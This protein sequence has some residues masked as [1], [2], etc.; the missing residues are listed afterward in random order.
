[1]MTAGILAILPIVLLSVVPAA[2]APL[3]GRH[4]LFFNEDGAKGLGILILVVIV[5][6]LLCTYFF[7][8]LYR[9]ATLG[10]RRSAAAQRKKD[11]DRAKKA[12]LLG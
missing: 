10:K 9:C 8:I 5:T 7:W 4:L 3:H 2:A 1:M 6:L 11:N 12:A